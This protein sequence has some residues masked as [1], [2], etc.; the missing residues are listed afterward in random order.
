LARSAPSWLIAGSVLIVAAIGYHLWMP[1][2]EAQATP[3]ALDRI[4][5]INVA[6]T[7]A[8]PADRAKLFDEA[9]AAYNA[10]IASGNLSPDDLT[11]AKSLFDNAKWL[12]KNGDPVAEAERLAIV[13]DQLLGRLQSAVRAKKMSQIAKA[14]KQYVDADR[15]ALNSWDDADKSHAADVIIETRLA[16]IIRQNLTRHELFESMMLSAGKQELEAIQKGADPVAHPRKGHKKSH[17]KPQR[18]P[19]SGSA[20]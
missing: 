7:E 4:L 6:L 15:T 1:S 2:S 17:K 3:D 10:A 5:D 14:A 18:T 16:T 9:Q 13:A 20:A 11:M 19:P 8:E 12:S